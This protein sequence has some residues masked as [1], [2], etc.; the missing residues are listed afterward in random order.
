[1]ST[2]AYSYLEEKDGKKE[3]SASFVSDATSD[4][5]KDC[6]RKFTMYYRKHHCR[7]CGLLVCSD[8][9]KDRLRINENEKLERVCIACSSLH[10]EKLR[11]GRKKMEKWTTEP[12]QG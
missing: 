12:M 9:S 3:F 7:R 8:C 6:N 11:I 4:Q 10:R 1:M 5:C 2:E